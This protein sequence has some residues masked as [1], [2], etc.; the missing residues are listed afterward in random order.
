MDQRRNT[1]LPVHQRVS[2]P[3]RE[4]RKPSPQ[5]HGILAERVVIATALDPFL[6]LKA[7]ASYAGLSVRKL[8]DVLEDP[9]HPLPCYRVGGKI[10]VRRSDFDLWIGQY[11]QIGQ[12][13]V[14]RVV[15]EVLQDLAR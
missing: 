13:N 11:R 5:V 15:A 10:L 1:P 7:L 6:P 12:Q 9:T 8:P 4:P 14:D 2:L 3:S